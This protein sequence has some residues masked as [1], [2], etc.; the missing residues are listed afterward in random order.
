LEPVA[1]GAEKFFTIL[2]LLFSVGNGAIKAPQYWQQRNE[3]S[4]M[5]A[6]EICTLHDV[7]YREMNVPRCWHRE[8][9]APRYW[10]QRNER[11]TILATEK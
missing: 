8:M 3:R 7:G 2:M 10:Q 6:T 5:L 4:T 9:N 1:N 11:S